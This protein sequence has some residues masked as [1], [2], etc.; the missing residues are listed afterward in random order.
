MYLHYHSGPWKRRILDLRH[1]WSHPHWGAAAQNHQTTAGSRLPGTSNMLTTRSFV[2]F[3]WRVWTFLNK[4]SELYIC[5]KYYG[6]LSLKDPLWFIMT[7]STLDGVSVSGSTSYQSWWVL[8]SR[9]RHQAR[10][11]PNSGNENNAFLNSQHQQTYPIQ[12]LKHK[13]QNRL[14]LWSY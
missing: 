7:L 8:I 11:Q 3:I 1:G 2:C 9:E 14:N 4:V 13:K 5:L 10:A 12:G 6:K